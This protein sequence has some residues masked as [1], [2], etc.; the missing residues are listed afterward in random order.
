MTY[1]E[2]VNSVLRRL[3][4]NQVSSVQ[5]T[6]YSILIGDFVNLVKREVEDSWD[7]GALRT[8]LTAT[9]ANSLFNYI[10]EDST[11]RIRV[12]DVLND[13]D[14]TIMEQRSSKWFNQQF[15]FTEPPQKGSPHYYNFNGV[16]DDGNVQ[17]DFFPVPDGVYE[18]RINCVLPQAPLSLNTDKIKVP[19]DVVIEGAIA[20]AISERGDDGGYMEQEMRYRSLLSDYIAIESAQR[21]DEVTWSVF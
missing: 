9:T 5:E 19:A 13:T 17:V 15:L 8:T 14:N 11:I 6:A 12:L 18:V 2:I 1:L 20:R 16:T 10:L 7:W 4:E 21:M 3:R